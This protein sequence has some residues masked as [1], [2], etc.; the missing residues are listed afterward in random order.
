MS[1]SIQ[2]GT[3]YI[4]KTAGMLGGRARIDG[5][6][7]GVS[8]VVNLYVRLGAPVEEI[9][10][11]YELTPAQ[12]YAALAYYYDHSEEIDAH[13]DAETQLA[14]K[15]VS[16]DALAERSRLKAKLNQRN[17]EAHAAMVS[18]PEHEMTVPEIAAE[19]GVSAQTIREAAQM[20]W[21]KARKAG[22][23]WLIKRRDAA[24]RWDKQ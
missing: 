1:E 11:S 7:I 18:N 3:N 12:V 4:V 21:V 9:V 2:V 16:D 24:Q 13:L 14:A 8:D 5:R 6:R 23:D 15:Y 20:G 22:R 10:E 19:F 17:P